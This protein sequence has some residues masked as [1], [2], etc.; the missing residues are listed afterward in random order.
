MKNLT[1]E[2][3]LKTVRELI[4]SKKDFFLNLSYI[5]KD[6]EGNLTKI[7]TIKD[8]SF[9]VGTS[10][11]Q[12]KKVKKAILTGLFNVSNV[13]KT[14]SGFSGLIE[15]FT[16]KKDNFM[17]DLILVNGL[18]K[19]N[20]EHSKNKAKSKDKASFDARSVR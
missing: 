7:R 6:L 9:V 3:E 20:I 19:I 4:L 8:K 14:S 18:F 5:F 11:N 1:M 16:S 17:F 10:E 13:E 15:V 2:R 12:A